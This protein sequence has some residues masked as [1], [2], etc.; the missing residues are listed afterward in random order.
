MKFFQPKFTT[1]EKQFFLDSVN[2]KLRELNKVF[3]QEGFKGFDLK[4]C[5]E[6]DSFEKLRNKIIK[7]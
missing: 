2:D 6:L 1:E 7:W 4:L 3:H 5:N